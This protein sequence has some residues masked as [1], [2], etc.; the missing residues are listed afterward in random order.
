[1][2]GDMKKKLK[3]GIVIVSVFVLLVLTGFCLYRY[4]VTDQI[5]DG[6][7]GMENPDA[8]EILDDTGEKP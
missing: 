5:M 1:M 7:G 4:F 3:M 8:I 6:G 2:I